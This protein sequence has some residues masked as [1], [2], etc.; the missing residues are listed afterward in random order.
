MFESGPNAA[1]EIPVIMQERLLQIGK[2]LEING[3]A[4]YG[5]QKWERSVQWSEGDREYDFESMYKS[6]VEGEYILLQ[7]VQPIEGKTF[8]EILSHQNGLVKNWLL[9][10]WS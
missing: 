6:Y 3:E 10:I 5:T 1:G 9:R 2:W 7:T 4:I 8:K